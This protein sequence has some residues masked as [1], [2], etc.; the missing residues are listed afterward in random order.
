MYLLEKKME[1]ERSKAEALQE[2]ITFKTKM[3]EQY[4]AD[5]NRKT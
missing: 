5:V 2:D 3:G 4:A 1:K